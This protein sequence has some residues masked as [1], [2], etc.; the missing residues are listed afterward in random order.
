MVFVVLVLAG[1]ASSTASEPL[2]DEGGNSP[3]PANYLFRDAGPTAAPTE[4]TPQTPPARSHVYLIVS[5]LALA[6]IFAARKFAP[7][8]VA[9]SIR[10]KLARRLPSLTPEGSPSTA[11]AKAEQL[12]NALAEEASLTV[13]AKDLHQA[14]SVPPVAIDSLPLH[15]ERRDKRDST[16]DPLEVFF[17]SAPGQLV[18][19]RR[20]LCQVSQAS[21]ALAREKAVVE[22]LDQVGSMK[23]RS[24]LPE[25][26]PVWLVA[27]ALEGLFKQLSRCAADFKS[28]VLKTVAAALDLLEG[29]CVRGLDPELGTRP[30]VRLLAVDDDAV[31]RLTLSLALKR[32]FNPPDVAPDG[33]TGLNLAAQQF[34]DVIFLDVDMPGMDG[35]EVCRKIHQ[36]VCNR[37]TPVVF[38]TRHGDFNSRAKS[39]LSGGQDLIAKPFLSFEITVKALTLA[40]RARLQ[41]GAM[42]PPPSGEEPVSEPVRAAV[43]PQTPADPASISA[44][45]GEN[46]NTNTA[47]PPALAS[48][49]SAVTPPIPN[50][51]DLLALIKA[52]GEESLNAFFD[53]AP[54][55]LQELRNQLHQAQRGTT[56]DKRQESLGRLYVGVHSLA[57]EAER[58]ELR[59]AF[60]LSSALEGMLKKLLE[61]TKLCTPAILNAA[62]AA[63]QLLEELCDRA[64]ANRDLTDPPAS[65]LVVDDDPVARRAISAA[66]QLGFGRPD[67]AES[68]EAALALTSE[69]RFDL[70]FLDV[71]M[72]GIDGFTTCSKIHQTDP[73]RRTPIVFVTSW[74]DA[75]AR[76][77]VVLSGGCGLIPKPVF[78]SQIKLVA[79]TFIMRV[80]CSRSNQAPLPAE[81]AF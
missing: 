2:A 13:L 5:I 79:L 69:K 16:P 78:A 31:T 63:L 47:E 51:L 9:A 4:M 11:A 22:F 42:T 30:P 27:G 35:Y 65:I 44:R 33:P 10:K 58:H 39:T 54:A 32:L 19:L 21:D 73:N 34:Y 24:Q 70:I 59:T 50:N 52:S 25:L 20:I 1:G 77:K 48:H 41:K 66:I 3:P 26:R 7:D 74:D 23:E 81:A 40:L 46:L 60:R 76:S 64:A 18:S 17:A 15:F 53:H 56:S 38:V 57:S 71:L 8:W 61:E 37:T 75:E 55:F 68:G 29:L 49:S 6:A 43:A 80:R 45:S 72:P 62:D 14:L 28:S 67:S 12:Q 36:T